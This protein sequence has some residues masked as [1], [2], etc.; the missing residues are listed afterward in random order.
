MKLSWHPAAKQFFK[1][2]GTRWN[3]DKTKLV[4]AFFY[5]GTHEKSAQQQ[6]EEIKNEWLKIKQ[7]WPSLRANLL[8]LGFPSLE[9]PFWYFDPT[10]KETKAKVVE[11]IA[12]VDRRYQEELASVE[13]PAISS[14]TVEQAMQRFITEQKNRIGM[15]GKKGLKQSTFLTIQATLKTATR[16]L[17]PQIPI[18]QLTHSK[19]KE[20]VDLHYSNSDISERAALNYCRSFKQ[21]LDWLEVQDSYG[22]TMKK[23]TGELF[24]LGMP[25]VDPYI[26][27][28]DE[29]KAVIQSAHSERCRLFM[30]LALNC[31]FTAVD[32]S[33]LKAD[34]VDLQ[35]GFIYRGRDK[36]SHQNK[37]KTLY[38]LFPETKALM[39]K[40]QAA[41]NPD[42]LFFLT[43]DGTKLEEAKAN[44][45][46]KNIT[47]CFQ[48]SK[49]KAKIE[50][51]FTFKSFRKY[52]A[53]T[54]QNQTKSDNIARMFLAHKIYGV[55]GN[56]VKDD[57]TQLT[58]ALEYYYKH[59]KTQKVI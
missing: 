27:T 15:K 21:F 36:T 51:D 58:E 52:G 25:A 47:E 28:T 44:H 6:A 1:S 43:K 24:K 20:L 48:K 9:K 30:L 56:Y 53:T 32:I 40:H 18:S 8:D 57:F 13:G 17:D 10:K 4:Q 11:V 54:I 34:E 31:G 3:G 23:Q 22:F 49:T 16:K 33:N 26:P 42:G 2:I 45:R 5:F 12:T 35:E 37:F 29:V 7:D 46:T 55:L 19:I 38:K 59:M 14:V 50:T 41:K 39:E